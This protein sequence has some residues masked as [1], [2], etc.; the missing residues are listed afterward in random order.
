MGQARKTIRDGIRLHEKPSS[1]GY[2]YCNFV[3]KNISTR[4]LILD[5][6]NSNYEAICKVF[7]FLG[8]RSKNPRFGKIISNY[9]SKNLDIQ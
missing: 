2:K 5:Y 3:E 7:F 4:D 8:E 9:F 6:N 1:K